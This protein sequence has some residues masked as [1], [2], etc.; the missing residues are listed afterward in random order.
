MSCRRLWQNVINMRPLRR[1][2]GF[3]LSAHV[4]WHKEDLVC[5]LQLWALPWP[6]DTFINSCASFKFEHGEY[7]AKRNLS[8]ATVV[9][10]LKP[11]FVCS[12]LVWRKMTEI[13]TLQKAAL[14]S[15]SV[16]CCLSHGKKTAESCS[17]LWSFLFLCVSLLLPPSPLSLCF[18]GGRLRQMS[19][20]AQGG[21]S[22]GQPQ[23]FRATGGQIQ[24]WQ[25]CVPGGHQKG[26]TL[27]NKLQVTCCRTKFWC[28]SALFICLQALYA[29][30]IISYAQG[31][32]LLRQAAK[33]FGWSL[34][35]G[36]IALMWRGGCIIRRYGPRVP[37]RAPL[38]NIPAC[39]PASL[40][41]MVKHAVRFSTNF[42]RKK[43][44]PNLH[45]SNEGVLLVHFFDFFFFATIQ[46]CNSALLVMKSETSL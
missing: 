21:A 24:R 46:S 7:S 9:E 5:C 38:C 44:C 27:K 20:L 6:H 15:W 11:W 16:A 43:S 2:E 36:A 42:L 29:S 25:G 19:V 8:V 12:L 22:G 31:F 4:K 34:N 26:K 23:P 45:C 10:T 30:K 35:Y 1:F 32:M 39:H 40:T 14:W 37:P 17:C 3:S 13:K 33:E 41:A 18:R 28:Q